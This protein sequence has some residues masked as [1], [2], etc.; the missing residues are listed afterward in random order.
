MVEVEVMWDGAVGR[1]WDEV[2]FTGDGVVLSVEDINHQ[3]MGFVKVLAVNLD[4]NSGGRAFEGTA[5][6]RDVTRD[7]TNF[8]IRGF[9][10]GGGL[11]DGTKAIAAMEGGG[12]H[13]EESGGRNVVGGGETVETKVDFLGLEPAVEAAVAFD[14][15]EVCQAVD[16]DEETDDADVLVDIHGRGSEA[17][18][19]L[20]ELVDVGDVAR[21]SKMTFGV[22]G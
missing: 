22:L 16:P 11:D 20:V 5:A 21:E 10:F 8:E 6:I 18:D 3:L 12:H 13:A 15:P 17:I 1:S 19:I 14:V 2:D 4:F 7:Q 9:D